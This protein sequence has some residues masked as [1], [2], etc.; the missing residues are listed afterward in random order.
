MD[1]TAELLD[2]SQL[3][4]VAGLEAGFVELAKRVGERNRIQ[5]ET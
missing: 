2:L 1:L 5:Y 3:D 4:D